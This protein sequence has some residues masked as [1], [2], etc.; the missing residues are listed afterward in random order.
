[1]V[2]CVK[3]SHS[4]EFFLRMTHL[5]KHMIRKENRGGKLVTVARSKNAF[6]HSAF[7]RALGLSM[8]F[9]ITMLAALPEVSRG[10]CPANTW[11]PPTLYC[12][13]YTGP[14]S[15]GPVTLAG[16]CQVN[17]TYCFQTC[18]ID[19]PGWP[20]SYTSVAIESISP[21]P[22]C[23][24]CDPLTPDQMIKLLLQKL[25]TT[26]SGGVGEG[27]PPPCTDGFTYVVTYAMD[28]WE[29]VPYQLNGQWYNS[30]VTCGNSNDYCE[31]DC[32]Y[33][34]NSD[35]SWS[36]TCSSESHD[37]GTCNPLPTPDNWQPNTCYDIQVCGG[38]N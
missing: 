4:R 9:A 8:L 26:G 11:T 1:V 31:T 34:K 6:F 27:G 16:G 35:G 18:Y 14:V 23:A 12:D 5:K 20:P 15:A 2:H 38:P 7:A 24:A 36:T 37:D 19:L 22:G 3:T 33:C 30:Y 28:C 32:K 13:P 21:V 29:D 25:E 10:Q 17:Y